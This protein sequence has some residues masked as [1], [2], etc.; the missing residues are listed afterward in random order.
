MFRS[1]VVAGDW[2]M[3]IE[4]LDAT[5]TMFGWASGRPSL[6]GITSVADLPAAVNGGSR[7][8][9][10][11][12][13]LV[14]VA[15]ADG[16]D[17]PD[18]VLVLLHLLADGAS[19]LASKFAHRTNHAVAMVVAELTCQIRSFPWRRR[20]EAI[21]AGLLLDTKHALWHG[22]F[23]PVEDGRAND[24]VLVDPA[25]WVELVGEPAGWASPEPELV[26]LFVWAAAQGV[27]DAGEIAVLLE[28][29]RCTGRNAQQR[30]ATTLGVSVKTV[31][32]RRD[33][34]VARLKAAAGDYLAAVA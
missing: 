31:R 3:L 19:A 15:A 13:A 8:D 22:E 7:P 11:L 33:R 12:W 29:M 4:R 5:A 34:A 24:A 14:Q 2:S 16:G 25:R 23:R 10:V 32:R 21:A 27:S 30:A 6:A 26:D 1:A 17:D 9:D 18:A 28:L 20:T